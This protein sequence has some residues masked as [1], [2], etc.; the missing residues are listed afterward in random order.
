MQ[1]DK[2][3]MQYF[4]IS[5]KKDLKACTCF[6]HIIAIFFFC[7]HLHLFG[8]LQCTE[9]QIYVFPEKELRG[10]STNSYIHVSVSDLYITRINPHI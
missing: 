7:I 6:S 10:L 4:L 1:T 8:V 9:N 3:N 5:V 2:I